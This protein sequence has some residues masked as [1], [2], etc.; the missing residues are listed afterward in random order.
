MNRNKF[1]TITLL[2]LTTIFIGTF[3]MQGQRG[4]MRGMNEKGLRCNIPDLSEEQQKKIDD[5]RT[6]H[7][8]NMLQYRN[9]MQE[10]RAKLNTLRTAEKA[11]MAAINKTVDEM[12]TLHT[13]MMK[14]RENHRQKVRGLLT[15]KQRVAYDTRLGRGCRGQYGMGKGRGGHRGGHGQGYGC[16]R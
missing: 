1:K 2:V 5:F 8:K 15:E 13:Q 4:Q 6:E 14:E 16:F 12:G 10:K 9:Q 3:Q 7:Q 11:D